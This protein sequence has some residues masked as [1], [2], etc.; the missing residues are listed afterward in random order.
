[1]FPWKHVH[2][3]GIGG[4]GL[5]AMASLLHQAGVKVTGS[6]LTH[7]LKTRSLE[8][9]GI[10]ISY[11]Q[12]GELINAG[13]SLVV[14]STAVP[15]DNL[16]LEN[17]KNIG[18]KVVSRQVLLKAICDCYESVIAI[19][20][21]HG[22]TTVTSMCA[23]LFQQSGTAAS[24][25]IGGELNSIDF[26]SAKF[27]PTGPLIIEA[28]ESD[29]TI[30]ALHASTG[31]L[32][33]TD[34]D[35]SWSVGGVNQL[36]D[37]FRKFSR[38]SKTIFAADENS[39]RTVLS[40]IDSINFVN[41]DGSLQLPQKGDFMRL[42]ASLAIEACVNEGLD[43]DPCKKHLES[44][45]GVQRRSQVH[46]ETAF[47][48][49]FEDYA[50]HPKELKALNSALEEQY[51]PYYKI[52]VFQVH[53]FERLESYVKEFA[54]ELKEFDKVFLAP[55]FSAWSK[56][57]DSP[58]LEQL[59]VLLSPKA[60]IFECENW[61]YNA[62]KVLAQTPTT[63]HCIITVIGA[64]TVKDIIPWLKNQLISHSLSERLPDLEILHEPEWSEITTLGAG[65]KQHA[66]YEPQSLE[67]LQELIKFAKRYS[68]K[69]LILGAGSN[70]VGSDQLFDG[71]IIR[72][73]LGDFAAITIDGLN[74]QVGAGVKWLRLIK[75][76]QE[77]NLGGIEALAAV[78]G[79]IGG[80]VRM[81]A[82][83]QG[84]E[85]ASF[86][87]E[88]TGLTMDAKIIFFKSEDIQWSYRSC[89]LADDFIVT[90]IKMKFQ[91]A[92]PQ[93]S[94][95]IVQS[96]REFRKKT[97]PGGRNPGCAFRNP[98]YLAAGL[99][100]E[101][102]GFKSLSFPH[103][104]VSDIHA[105]FFINE[106]KCSADEYARLMEYVQ[107]GI[108]N[109]CGI[110]LQQEVVFSDQRKINAVKALK[111]TVLKG[112]PSSERPISLK[113]AEAVAK[114]LRDGGHKVE[115]IDLNDFTLPQI[116]KDCDL[117][118]P[119]LHGEFGEDG[120]VQKLIEEQG[121]PYVGCDISSSQLCIDK[122]ATVCAL[123]KAG[124][125]VCESIVLRSKE[126]LIPSN[127]KLPVVVKP[128][129]Q[130]SSICLSLVEKEE[131]L[132][133]AIQ[134]AFENDDTVLVESFFQGI[135]CT[136]G[137]ID[138]K[139]LSLVEIIP[140][141][142]FFDYDA[143]YTYSKGQTQYNCPPKQIPSEVCER[144]KQCAEETFK[145][146]KGRQLMRVDMIWN[147]ESDKFI[148][149]EAN[150]MPGFT[151]SSLLPKAA[152]YDGVSFTELCCSLAKN[153]L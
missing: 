146:L 13:I 2:F 22:K 14:M 93:R 120:Q 71:I 70:M 133:K 84:L 58:S 103:C 141:E 64:A 18:L 83:A 68:L 44:F 54:A 20:G 48:T 98:G 131:D 40:G 75:T 121:F 148:I 123:R 147:Q 128:N 105:N 26:P 139:A 124:L 6:D 23:W 112:G 88:V 42:N 34:D 4:A 28:D 106:D 39:C 67:E 108:Y 79:S 99:L 36:Y 25:M 5:S 96:T 51:D 59:R 32:V 86:V 125:P 61:E 3:I 21:S 60:E 49:L 153:A 101:K 10:A 15:S 52:A 102:Y 50:H 138:G 53:R 97:Q 109:A 117:I 104:A 56:R 27:D 43:K 78:P 72:L 119:V 135:E 118:F 63:E 17:A 57:N 76:L 95:A 140:P 149:L 142:G 100:I 89:S 12:E 90:S 129:R 137:I 111:I 132:E 81:N 85:T 80:G 11:H 65:I 92:V 69:T 134:L 77:H 41:T 33:N 126:E 35:H 38:Q 87:L 113:S 150:T 24:W 19:G 82:G 16:E 74:A 30:A 31:V 127:I 91:R 107:S 55:P 7:S 152:K 122:D 130:G 46:F 116:A 110:R 62:E 136:V 1:M 66:C 8:D 114:A 29:G 145:V 144:L 73:R 9:M 143:K 115:E 151:S 47:L 94:K 37:N 45:C